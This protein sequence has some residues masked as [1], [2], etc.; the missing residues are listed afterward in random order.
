MF[1]AIRT[2]FVSRW[3]DFW[4]RKICMIREYFLW[5]TVLMYQLGLWDIS[6]IKLQSCDPFPLVSFL[7]FVSCTLFFFI[8]LHA[9]LV[10][11][12]SYPV[13]SVLK[14]FKISLSFGSID[15]IAS[16]SSFWY[17]I[18]FVARWNLKKTTIF[19]QFS[20]LFPKTLNHDIT[21]VNELET[22]RKKCVEKVWKRRNS[23]SRWWKKLKSLN[24]QMARKLR[25]CV[26]MSE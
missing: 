15:V 22:E 21:Q 10:K 25:Y 1:F 24:P 9:D 14:H 11:K 8:Y 5:F 12:K 2:E 3:V 26:Y 23:F 19:P 4:S 18:H 16:Q 13:N 7:D 6:S 20:L 17:V